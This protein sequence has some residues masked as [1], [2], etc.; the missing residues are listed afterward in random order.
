M[1]VHNEP[2]EQMCSEVEAEVVL[3]PGAYV[4]AAGSQG[5]RGQGNSELLGTSARLAGSGSAV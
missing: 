3:E 5:G 1:W 2:R 4:C